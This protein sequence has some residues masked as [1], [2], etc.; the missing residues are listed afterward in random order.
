MKDFSPRFPVMVSELPN[1]EF[2][3]ILFVRSVYIPGDERS[4]TN[5]GHGYPGGT[6]NYWNIE[7][8][9]NREDWEAEIIKQTNQRTTFK[10]VK[11]T[12]AKIQ[13][14]ISVSE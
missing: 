6:E 2:Y 9:K 5:P 11:M 12:P 10:A 4:R 14:T 3:A 8:Y 7:V 13:T 1:E